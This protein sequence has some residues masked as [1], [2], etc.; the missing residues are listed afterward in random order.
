MSG[1]LG[2]STLGIAM[3]M[4]P[5]APGAGSNDDPSLRLPF[6]HLGISAIAW[7]ALP[8]SSFLSLVLKWPKLYLNSLLASVLLA[9]L[10]YPSQCL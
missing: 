8:S 3:N 4:A 10:P 9:S 5:F 2:L 1:L 7:H 6:L